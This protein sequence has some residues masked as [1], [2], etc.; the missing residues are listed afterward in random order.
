LGAIASKK[1]EVFY[2]FL[3][4]ESPAPVG[5]A[6]SGRVGINKWQKREQV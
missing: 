5:E 2:V 4:A 3:D 6:V 1:V